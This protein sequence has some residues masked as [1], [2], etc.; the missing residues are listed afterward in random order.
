MLEHLVTVKALVVRRLRHSYRQAF[1]FGAIGAL[2]GVL[3]GAGHWPGRIEQRGML[4]FLEHF[5]MDSISITVAALIISFGI[6]LCVERPADLIG[7]PWCFVIMLVIGTAVATLI[8]WT[9]HVQLGHGG[10]SALAD[11]S[12][13]IVNFWMQ[14][15]L[16]GG[17][18]GWTYLL[19][20]QRAEDQAV[21]ASLLGKRILLA[22]QLA[23]SRL[24]AARARIDPAMVARVLNEVHARYRSAPA[25]ASVLLDHLISYLRLAMNRIRSDNPTVAGEITLIRA[26][27][28]MREVQHGIVVQVDVALSQDD[29]KA[30]SGPMFL[31]ASALLDDAIDSGARSARLYLEKRFEHISVELETGILEVKLGQAEAL[32]SLIAKLIPAGWP[33]LERIVKSGASKYVVKQV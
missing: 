6:R 22:R 11:R 5:G 12:Q 15:M 28:A 33:A 4:N 13:R 26:L 31:V 1:L 19:S 29:C 14:A 18:I 20:L 25:E 16:F 10:M 32:S 2:V 8:A 24:G 21:L 7:R 3:S 30:R 17:L 27:A 9:I 23:R